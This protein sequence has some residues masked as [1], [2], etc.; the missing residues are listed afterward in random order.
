VFGLK[1]SLTPELL[2]SIYLFKLLFIHRFLRVRLS[3]V[4]GFVLIGLDHVTVLE[5][6]AF[7][8]V[9]GLFLIVVDIDD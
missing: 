3:C 7:V 1:S 5:F 2:R 9:W 4:L 8:G 6:D